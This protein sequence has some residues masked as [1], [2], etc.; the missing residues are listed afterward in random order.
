MKEGGNFFFPWRLYEIMP[1][2]QA[3]GKGWRLGRVDFVSSYT[4]SHVRVAIRSKLLTYIWRVLSGIRHF[5][6]R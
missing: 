4:N 6:W 3:K 1:P 2:I 5:Y